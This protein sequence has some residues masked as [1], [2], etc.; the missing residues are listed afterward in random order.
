MDVKVNVCNTIVDF[1]YSLI[2]RKCRPENL[3]NLFIITRN[4]TAN[5][6]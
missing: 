5:Q 2:K 1:I 4:N 3:Y 6:S